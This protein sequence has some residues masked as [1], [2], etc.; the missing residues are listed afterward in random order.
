MLSNPVSLKAK[1]QEIFFI[2]MKSDIQKSGQK[3]ANSHDPEMPEKTN[4]MKKINYFFHFY[5]NWMSMNK[6]D[7]FFL[8]I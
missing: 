5:L 4:A 8:K 2:V 1:N 6:S 7:W 3:G